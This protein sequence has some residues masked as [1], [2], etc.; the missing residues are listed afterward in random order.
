MIHDC[1][2]RAASAP[3]WMESGS[4]CGRPRPP[5]QVLPTRQFDS[6]WSQQ[7][8]NPQGSGCPCHPSEPWGK[9]RRSRRTTPPGAT[10]RA[11][12]RRRCRRL[13]PRPRS[14]PARLRDPQAKH[15]Q[16]VA[17]PQLGSSYGRRCRRRLLP[18]SRGNGSNCCPGE[19]TLRRNM[20]Q[21]RCPCSCTS[22]RGTG[23]AIYSPRHPKP[24][25]RPWPGSGATAGPLCSRQG[26]VLRR[27]A[28]RRGR[29]EAQPCD[30]QQR[31][32]TQQIRR[33]RRRKTSHA[34]VPGRAS[35]CRCARPSR[36]CS[37]PL[38]VAAAAAAQPRGDRG[39]RSAERKSCFP[40]MRRPRP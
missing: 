22:P 40:C 32:Q 19:A 34:V 15:G 3:M 12:R 33:R 24:R 29:R 9:A 37:R 28:S 30:R 6:P 31:A 38:A 16:K 26:R 36:I 23:P 4:W 2:A 17:V 35:L 18:T 21:P 1:S 25:N 39:H 14:G 27:S 11:A 13:P 7:R 10:I 8:R 20:R 5:R